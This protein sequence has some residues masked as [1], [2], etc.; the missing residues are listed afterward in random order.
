[1]TGVRKAKQAVEMQTIDVMNG[2]DLM[3]ITTEI[4][5]IQ[6]LSFYWTLLLFVSFARVTGWDILCVR[7]NTTLPHRTSA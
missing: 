3:R 2:N 4:K 6:V 5:P 7:R 1:M